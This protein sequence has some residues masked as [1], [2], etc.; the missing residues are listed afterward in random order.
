VVG[1]QP[2]GGHGLSGTGPKAGGPLYLLRLLSR[3]PAQQPAAGEVE[4]VG[5]VGERNSYSLRPKGTILCVAADPQA[6]QAEVDAARA[7]GNRHTTNE[8]DP[9]IRAALFSGDA[10]ELLALGK[11]LAMREGPVVPVYTAPYPVE[12]LTDEVSLSV[13]TAAAGGNASLMTIG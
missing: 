5:P 12:F 7:A 6:L 11:R 8:K 9:A 3:R 4:L 13:N 1:V 10:V 2:F